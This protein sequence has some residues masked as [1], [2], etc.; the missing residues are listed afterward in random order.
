MLKSISEILEQCSKLS[1]VNDRANFL[2]ENESEPLK[3]ILFYA[4]DPRA[5]WE[6]PKGEPPYKPCDFLDQEA[7]LYQEARRL[8]LFIKGGNADLHVYKRE[9]MFIQILESVDAKDAKLLCSV[10]DKKIPYKGITANVVNTAF[11]GLIQEKE[12]EEK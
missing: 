1:S 6:L 12:K 11:P 5:V 8:Y 4:L 7:R 9:K 3:A 2:R 10:K